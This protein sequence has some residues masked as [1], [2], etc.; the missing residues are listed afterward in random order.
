LVFSELRSG[1]YYNR[2]NRHSNRRSERG[3]PGRDGG[4]KDRGLRG[5]KKGDC[6]KGGK[7]GSQTWA[8]SK[9]RKWRRGRGRGRIPAKCSR[10]G[11]E[12]NNTLRREEG[13]PLGKKFQKI[14]KN[15][16]TR[17]CSKKKKDQVRAGA[18]GFTLTIRGVGFKEPEK[19]G[20]R[21][22]SSRKGSF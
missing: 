10:K 13:P 5:G 20:G 19:Q 9:R 14:R 18:E 3:P 17:V 7:R 22:R 12:T 8:T 16:S 4:R 6:G 15:S 21:E 11:E 2:K 1:V